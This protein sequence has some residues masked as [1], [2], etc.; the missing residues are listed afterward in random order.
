M[1]ESFDWKCK[2][3]SSEF[4]ILMGHSGPWSME[5]V[6]LKCGEVGEDQHFLAVE[7]REAEKMKEKAA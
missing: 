6:C 7:A 5:P 2:C 1:A 3:G 4:E